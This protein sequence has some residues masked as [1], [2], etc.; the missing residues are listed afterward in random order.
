MKQINQNEQDRL[1]R[2]EKAEQENMAARKKMAAEMIDEMNRRINKKTRQDQLREDLDKS[3]DLM[4]R[5]RMKQAEEDRLFDLKILQEQKAKAVSL[6]KRS[7]PL[8]FI[9][10]MDILTASSP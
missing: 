8:W 2:L 1:L 4:R 6:A 7:N 5:L 9:C 3:T 10:S